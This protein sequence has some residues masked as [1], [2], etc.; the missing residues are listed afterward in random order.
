MP[1]IVEAYPAAVVRKIIDNSN[2]KNDITKK[3]ASG[4][5]IATKSKVVGVESKNRQ[6]IQGL[7][8]ILEN[9]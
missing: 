1:L 2:Y 4:T 7:Y 5:R 6:D 9:H 8:I 3:T